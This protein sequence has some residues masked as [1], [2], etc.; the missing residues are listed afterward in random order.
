MLL[1]LNCYLSFLLFMATMG[2]AI[3]GDSDRVTGRIV[4]AIVFLFFYVF[5][6]IL[7]R[8]ADQVLADRRA[9]K[10]KA[11]GVKTEK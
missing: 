9:E 11:E 6:A 1:K 3:F 4:A 2:L 8:A 10:T 7:A 5:L